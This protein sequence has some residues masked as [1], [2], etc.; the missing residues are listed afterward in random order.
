MRTCHFHQEGIWLYQFCIGESFQQLHVEDNGTVSEQFYLGHFNES[1]PKETFGH[2][3]AS[4]QSSNISFLL[5]EKN[6][7]LEVDRKSGY[8]VRAFNNKGRDTFTL[9]DHYLMIPLKN[10]SGSVRLKV[11]QVVNQHTV[12]MEAPFPI[13]EVF[14]FVQD[15][16]VIP[17]AKHEL[18]EDLMSQEERSAH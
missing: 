13:D 10:D 5:D 18:K 1:S 16:K 3:N 15:F 9:K 4:N 8:I 11:L 7:Y 17:V 14:T 2:F 12:I 6:P